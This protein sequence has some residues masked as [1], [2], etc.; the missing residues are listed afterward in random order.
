MHGILFLVA[1]AAYLS[2][3]YRR[4]CSEDAGGARAAPPHRNG[5]L[6]A[7][8][9]RAHHA[10]RAIVVWPPARL[11]LVLLPICWYT[12]A[13]FNAAR[14]SA[15]CGQPCDAHG[16]TWRFRKDIAGGFIIGAIEY[17]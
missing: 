2:P 11:S 3:I 8:V 12:G 7:V 13:L 16:N 9:S 5:T 1:Q 15:L 6:F 17:A 10:L 4:S 14:I